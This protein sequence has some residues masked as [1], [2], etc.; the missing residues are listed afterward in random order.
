V[1]ALQDAILTIAA[2]EVGTREDG[3]NNR[4]VR[5]EEYQRA[6]WIAVGAWPWCAAFC[7][8][9]LR[10]AIRQSGRQLKHCPDPA[11]YGWER[12]G[13]NHGW[14]L[15]TEAERAQPGDF[16]TFDFSH[17]GI[18]TADAGDTILTIEGNTNGRGDRDSVSGDGVWRK[19]RARGLV[20]TFL[21]IPDALA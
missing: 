18:V 19:E 2:A 20:K 16:V 14:A 15:L 13:R 5:I 6:T 17:I 11:A 4:G 9:V 12:W 7:A 3:G 1:S 10:E 8:W 21:R